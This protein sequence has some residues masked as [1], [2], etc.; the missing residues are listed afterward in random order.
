MGFT[1]DTI[2]DIW[3]AIYRISAHLSNIIFYFFP[4][5]RWSSF[6]PPYE[7][8]KWRDVYKEEE[9]K[10][11]LADLGKIVEIR[12]NLFSD[13]EAKFEVQKIIKNLDDS[14]KKVNIYLDRG[15]SSGIT[16]A[17]VFEIK[18][19]IDGYMLKGAKNCRKE[20][21]VKA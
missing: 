7:P 2:G 1:I 20:G 3:F 10:S 16:M 8:G 5:E 4:A 9:I 21:E 15:E 14:I 17:K 13:N 12:T 18:N 19:K 6:A 11:N